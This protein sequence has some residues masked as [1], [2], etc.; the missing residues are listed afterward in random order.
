MVTGG[1]A[2]DAATAREDELGIEASGSVAREIIHGP[3][4]ARLEPGTETAARGRRVRSRDVAEVE[5]QV[6]GVLFDLLGQPVRRHVPVGTGCRRASRA[7][8]ATV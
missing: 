5:T 8:G 7:G 3:V 2:D 4:A 6:Q 1:E